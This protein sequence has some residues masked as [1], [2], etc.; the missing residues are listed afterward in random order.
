MTRVFKSKVER[1]NFSDE[2][3]TWQNQEQQHNGEVSCQVGSARNLT[4]RICRVHRMKM[5]TK[6]TARELRYTI[7]LSVAGDFALYL[8]SKFPEP[9]CFSIQ[10][11]CAAVRGGGHSRPLD[12]ST[13][14]A[15]S[16]GRRDVKGGG[17]LPPVKK[18]IGS[19]GIFWFHT[20][21]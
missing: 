12:Y 1:E 19:F 4:C 20:S 15:A 16:R 21:S 18:V 9:L 8:Y 2:K 6:C 5:K 13:Y 3:V 17:D 10:G 14:F 7:V 11:K